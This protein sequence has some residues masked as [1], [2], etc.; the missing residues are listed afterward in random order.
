MPLVTGEAKTL[1]NGVSR[2]PQHL[3]MPGQ[4]QDAVNAVFSVETGGFEKRGGGKDLMVMPNPVPGGNV[5]AHFINRDPTERYSIT[6]HNAGLIIHSLIDG[7]RKTI[8]YTGNSLAYVTNGNPEVDFVF[9][10]VADYTLILNKNV[11]VAADPSNTTPV[12]VHGAVLTVLQ[13]QGNVTITI[14]GSVALNNF[15]FTSTD[16]P[17]VTASKI[18]TNLQAALPGWSI[19]AVDNYVFISAPANAAFTIDKA[20][21]GGYVQ[22]CSNILGD[23]TKLPAKAINGMIVE[24]ATGA[25]DTGVT[26]ATG[27]YL[28][29]NSFSSTDNSGVWQECAKPGI[30]LGLDA[31]TLPHA[32]VRN[33]DGTFTVQQLTWKPRAVGD[34][35]TCPDPAFVGATLSECAFYRNRLILCA[36]ETTYLSAEGD[37]FNYYP[38]HTTQ[39][40]DSDAFALTASSNEVS[41]IKYALPFRK[42]LFL[43]S[44][45]AQYECA[46]PDV[47]TP[48][49]LSI[50]L[51]TTYELQPRARP[52][53]L[54]DSLFMAST[55]GPFTVILEYIYDYLYE[56]NTAT[57]IAKHVHGYIPTPVIYMD[58]D[59]VTGTLVMMCDNK[60][61]NSLYIYNYFWQGQQ[62]EQASFHRWQLNCDR[63]AGFKI[64][65]GTLYVVCTKYGE[66]ELHLLAVDIGR[67]IPSG[68]PFRMCMDYWTAIQGTYNAV[69]DS[70][71]WTLPFNN[72]ASVVPGSVLERETSIPVVGASGIPFYNEGV[73]RSS[74]ILRESQDCGLACVPSTSFGAVGIP[75]LYTKANDPYSVY[76]S[77]DW[78]AFPCAI[79]ELYN[80]QVQL[81]RT[82]LR[83]QTGAAVLE[84]RTQLREF[85]FAYVDSGYFVVTIQPEGRPARSVHYDSRYVGRPDATVGTVPIRTG[86]FTVRPMSRGDTTDIVVSNYT[87]IP[88][89]IVSTSWVGTYSTIYKGG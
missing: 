50:D 30:S 84:G 1:F 34:L 24:I 43:S 83:D 55:I 10:T 68:Y 20:D 11:V 3:R 18:G 22:L 28:Q 12:G 67:S 17:G 80:T 46:T 25:G 27:Y 66:T 65:D 51:A 23:A 58:G 72:T 86:L 26:T 74:P 70:T 89:S 54:G 9:N 85:R 35:T 6:H 2:Q 64:I 52:C 40:I 78:S 69:T 38:S 87:Q 41:V 75:A 42:T 36:A 16:L 32:L 81:S 47:V 15:A 61:R 29:F 19:Y 37:Y 48:T 21:S 73:Y 63:I 77:G 49:K 5:A 7:S 8:N 56:T 45:R 76:A 39:V 13:S 53:A 57:D 79:G 60:P 31:T 59:A 71:H 4:V 44:D 14:N 33:S 82:W 62:K 88:F